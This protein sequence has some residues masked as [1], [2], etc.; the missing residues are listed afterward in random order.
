MSRLRLTAFL[1]LGLTLI[2]GGC[3]APDEDAA[4]PTTDTAQDAQPTSE[5]APSSATASEDKLASH[6]AASQAAIKA[7]AGQ[8]KQA[9]GKAMKEG[10]PPKAIA[11]CNDV[12]PEIMQE[13]A[14]AKNLQIGRTSLKVRNQDNAPDDWEHSVLKQFEDQAAAGEPIKQLEVAEVVSK[15]GQQFYR[16]MKAIPTQEVCLACH[17]QDIAPKITQKLDKFYPND[18]ARGYEKGDVRGAFTIVMPM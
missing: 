16:Y 2:L 15:E 12:A 7:F 5:M 6:K 4:Q 1:G 10:G 3:Q 8:L 18:Q 9:L 13:V 17:G 11:V 14:A